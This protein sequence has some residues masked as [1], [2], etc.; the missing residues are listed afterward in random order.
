M[1]PSSVC[2]IEHKA[3]SLRVR[4]VPDETG[5]IDR[6]SATRRGTVRCFVHSF[7]SFPDPYSRKGDKV[8]GD[9]TE[10]R[11]MV[12]KLCNIEDVSDQVENTQS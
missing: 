10:Q 11:Q 3:D 1:V 9:C 5:H 4:A 7:R 6:L 8:C 2:F 12:A